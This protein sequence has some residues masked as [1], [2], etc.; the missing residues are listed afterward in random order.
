[1]FSA[2]AFYYQDSIIYFP[3]VL[4]NYLTP[5]KNPPGLRY[6][7]EYN[8]RYEDLKINSSDAVVLHAWLMYT[9]EP[10]G[11]PTVIFFQGNAGS[12][13]RL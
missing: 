12:E 4:P 8:I 6:P 9:K 10:R 1:M 13:C 2:L 3:K 5:D 7:S 11:K